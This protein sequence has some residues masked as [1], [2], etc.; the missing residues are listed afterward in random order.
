MSQRNQ[1]FAEAVPETASSMACSSNGSDQA[2]LLNALLED[3][4]SQDIFDLPADLGSFPG[5]LPHEGI[6]V[7]LDSLQLEA[8]AV[9]EEAG[10]VEAANR[11]VSSRESLVAHYLQRGREARRSALGRP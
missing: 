10:P 8:E 3:A 7:T 2:G 11:P 4:M 9:A 1:A 5:G 6:P